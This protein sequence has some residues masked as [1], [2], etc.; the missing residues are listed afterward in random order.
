MV[1][2]RPDRAPNPPPLTVAASVVGVQGVVLVGLAVVEASS[3]VDGRVEVAVSTA[4]FFAVYG[5]VLLASALALTR[6]WGWARGP[7]LISQLIA[8]GLAWNVRDAPLLAVAL[9]IA[10]LVALAG[11]LSPASIDVLMPRTEDPDAG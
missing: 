5:V 1:E 3:A 2:P 4:V 11:M 9:A 8:L 6:R 10:A 7:V